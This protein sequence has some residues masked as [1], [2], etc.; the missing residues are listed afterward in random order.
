VMDEYTVRTAADDPALAHQIQ[1]MIEE[2]WPRYI[3]QASS[4]PGH[5]FKVDWWG[6]YKRWP[7]YQI[8]LFDTDGETIIAS[9][10]GQSIAWDGQAEDLPDEGW[11]WLIDQ[12][13][14]DFNAD[15]APKTLCALSVTIRPDVRGKNLSRLML[16]L[17]RDFAR[18]DGFT[19]MIVPVRPNFKERYPI[20][21]IDEYVSWRTDEG[22]PFDPWLRVHARMGARIVKP[23][24]RA[25]TLGGTVA[26]WETWTNMKF[27][28]SGDYVVPQLLAPLHVDR[29]ADGCLHV[30]PN[31][32]VV[33]EQ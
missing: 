30:E 29:A 17:M 13:L 4:P 12:G 27:P 18:R 20:T 22:L 23:C 28:G 2:I 9:A 16:E 14:K 3:T 31:V 11:D 10:N 21:P 8:A 6:V 32:W 33:H 15:L 25:V 26:E 24:P 5:P 7:Q 19:R 1:D